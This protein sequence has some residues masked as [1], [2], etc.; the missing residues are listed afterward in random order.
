MPVEKWKDVMVN[1]FEDSVFALY[2][3]IAAIKDK[4]YD[5]GAVYASMSGSGSSVY[6]LFRQ[7]IENVDEKFAGCF[8]RQREMF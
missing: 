2:P 7:P 3:E 5:L 6:G 8:C 1:D 4:M